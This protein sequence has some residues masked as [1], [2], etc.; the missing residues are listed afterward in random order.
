[1]KKF[2][3]VGLICLFGMSAFGAEVKSARLDAQKQNILIDV[4]YGGGCGEHEFSLKMVGG[5]LETYPV[6]CTAELVERTNDMCEALIADTVVISLEKYGLNDSYFE[7]ATLKIVGGGSS[8][9]VQL[10]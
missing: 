5:C 8:A 3:I 10:P 6:R 7:R 9:T 2:A 1:M 4:V